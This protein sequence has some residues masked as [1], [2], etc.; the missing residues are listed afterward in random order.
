[1]AV[2]TKKNIQV[3]DSRLN[4]IQTLSLD[5]IGF[6]P[7]SVSISDS[8]IFSYTQENSMLST[9]ISYSSGRVESAL[10]LRKML[11]GYAKMKS[12]GAR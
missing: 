5:S 10:V 6:E 4:P 11:T 8:G 2:A 12:Q 7:D 1:V 3:F 9:T